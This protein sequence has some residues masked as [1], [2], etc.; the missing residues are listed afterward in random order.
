M[1]N[2]EVQ[3]FG[4]SFYTAV[5]G[6]DMFKGGDEAT[7]VTFTIEGRWPECARDGQKKIKI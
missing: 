4:L 5:P 7:L 3:R 2:S 1:I 6:D